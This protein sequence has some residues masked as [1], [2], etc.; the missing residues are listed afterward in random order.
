MDNNFINH[1]HNQNIFLTIEDVLNYL[2]II[3]FFTNATKLYT[4]YNN[5]KTYIS[6]YIQFPVNNK[7]IDKYKIYI[8]KEYFIKGTIFFSDRKVYD[9]IIELIKLD[10]KMYFNNTM[11]EIN[12]IIYDNS[13][14]HGL[15]RLFGMIKID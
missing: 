5:N 7:I 3:Y 4:I 15:E 13:P 1:N 11:Y 14:V 10:W 6:K 8:D 9:K 2:F 12:A